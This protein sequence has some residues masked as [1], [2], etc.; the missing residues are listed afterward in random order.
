MAVLHLLQSSFVLFGPFPPKLR[1]NDRL[2]FS[3]V[4]MGLAGGRVLPTP[5]GVVWAIST[6]PKK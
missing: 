6:G 3:P 2:D 4:W 5:V 1:Q